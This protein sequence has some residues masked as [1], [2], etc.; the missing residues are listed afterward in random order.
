DRLGP[1][2]IVIGDNV[3]LS[4]GKPMDVHLHLA[5]ADEDA[6]GRDRC[7]RVV[8]AFPPVGDERVGAAAKGNRDVAEALRG[9]GALMNLPAL[10]SGCEDI[11]AG[12]IRIDVNAQRSM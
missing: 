10:P 7:V 4:G 8:S 3:V 1:D 6:I 5:T 2:G 11:L 9:A 12:D